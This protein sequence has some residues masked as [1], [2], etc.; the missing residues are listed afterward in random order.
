LGFRCQ[1]GARIGLVFLP[2]SSLIF[3]FSDYGF[4]F[5]VKSVAKKI[6]ARAH[7]WFA[8][9]RAG[10]PDTPTPTRRA[11]AIAASRPNRGAITARPAARPRAEPA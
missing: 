1:R 2:V 3:D 8:P 11:R 6:R 10:G 7:M 4:D 5:Q 9:G